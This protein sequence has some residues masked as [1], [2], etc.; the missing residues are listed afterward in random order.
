MLVSNI[1]ISSVTTEPIKKLIISELSGEVEHTKPTLR[2]TQVTLRK[3][4]LS[5][6][7]LLNKIRVNIASKLVMQINHGDKIKFKAKLF[8][9]QS[10]VLPGTYDFGFYMYMSGI[11]A[12][13]YALTP[14]IIQNTD[15]KFFSNVIQNIR[16]K[17]YYRLLNVLGPREGNFAAAIIIGETK[18]IPKDLLENMRNS[19]V[20]H[21]LSVSGLHLSLITMICFVFSRLLLN[22]SNY[23]AYNFNIKLVAAFISIVGSFIYLQIS[24]GNIAATRAFIMTSIFIV[25]VML[26]RSPYPLRSVMIAAFLILLFLP[27]YIFHPSFQLSFAAVLCLISGY[28]F[29]FKN[30]Y[31]LGKSKGLISSVKLYV[32]A[33]IYSS[34]LASI[35]T[36]PFVIYHFYK[37]AT[38]SVAMKLNSRTVNVIFYHASCHVFSN[39]YT[40][41]VR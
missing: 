41:W 6:G 40:N 8:P 32:F 9:L 15:A 1:R 28:E 36:A 25:A 10:S 12:S 37:F 19:G 5:N 27:E 39:S 23:L 18:A 16:K 14:P 21:I 35:I 20:A 38:Y 22:C 4:A 7:R 11:E 2:G 30:K 3:V 13:G 17:I 34:F 26:G 24:G 33:N 29:Y 31:I